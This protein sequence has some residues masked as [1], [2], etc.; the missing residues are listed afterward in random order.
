MRQVFHDQSLQ[1]SF[2]KN[3][4]VKIKL[5]DNAQIESLKQIYLELTLD[6]TPDGFFSTVGAATM[7]KK[8]LHYQFARYF[9]N[10]FSY[11]LID[12]KPVSSNFITKKSSDSKMNFHQDWSFIDE[13]TGKCSLN[14]WCPLVDTFHDNGN[15]VVVPGSHN[16]NYQARTSNYHY[17]PYDPY[18]DCLKEL[19]KEIPTAAGEAIIFDNALLHG[20]P[21]N[22]TG[23]NR[24][25]VSL[26]SIPKEES[27]II[28]HITGDKKNIYLYKVDDEYLLEYNPFV[29]VPAQELL[30]RQIAVSTPDDPLEELKQL[31][32]RQ[33]KFAASGFFKRVLSSFK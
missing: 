23:T 30:Y 4:Y 29:D 12:Y 14:T 8:L 7:L 9:S 20:S 16:L 10:L 26:L 5:L 27:I 11:V 28:H 33:Q 17:S 22:I 2:E 15:L 1:N 6:N 24:L 31:K 32:T 25:T 13:S 18:Q 3:G 19:G 21:P